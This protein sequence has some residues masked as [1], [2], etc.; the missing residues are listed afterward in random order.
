MKIDFDENTG[1]LAISSYA[2]GWIRVGEQRIDSP[3]V[4][5]PMTIRTDILPATVDAFSLEHC[6]ALLELKP[7]ILLLGTGLRQRFVDHTLHRYL[8]AAGVGLEVMNLGAACR[9]F[10]VL[11]GEQRAVVAALFMD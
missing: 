8:A 10:N 4:V 2:D 6:T 1:L 5:T 11:V 9:S 3:C 7:E